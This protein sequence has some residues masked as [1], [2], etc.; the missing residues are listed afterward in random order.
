MKFCQRRQNHEPLILQNPEFQLVILATY[1]LL[2]FTKITI[3][4]QAANLPFAL[5]KHG[6]T[7]V[8]PPD[9]TKFLYK[10]N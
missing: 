4:D 1:F 8:A 2:S 9:D 3:L 7:C 10:K 6:A 5:K